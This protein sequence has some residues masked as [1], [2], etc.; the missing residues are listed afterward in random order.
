M[1]ECPLCALTP[2]LWL[3]T[4]AC[5]PSMS[6]LSGDNHEHWK[7]IALALFFISKLLLA[8]HSLNKYANA[9]TKCKHQVQNVG[10]AVGMG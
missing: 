10:H 9:M 3:L 7:H 1:G 5:H 8:F 2:A 6:A 4:G